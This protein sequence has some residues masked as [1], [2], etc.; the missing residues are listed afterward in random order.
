MKR[1]IA[2]VAALA[3]VLVLPAGAAAAPPPNDLPGGAI[4]LTGTVPA[5]IAQDTSEATVTE[6]DDVG[7]G[8][9]GVDQATVWYTITPAQDVHLLIDA[10]ESSY[11]VGI[12]TF[13]PGTP[14]GGVVPHEAEGPVFYVQD[15]GIGIPERHWGTVFDMFKRLHPRDAY[16]GGTGSG[17][18]IVKKVIEKHGGRIW[19]ESEPGRGTTFYFTLRGEQPGARENEPPSR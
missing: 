5:P 16:G 4:A 18:A 12:N 19:L 15:N 10:S 2:V 14:A 6:D 7:C 1:L 13:A 9:G 3:L 8:S 11:R 17:L